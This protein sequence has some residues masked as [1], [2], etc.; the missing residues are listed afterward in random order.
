LVIP[1]TSLSW[2]PDAKGVLSAELT[3]A[4]ADQD[5]HGSWKARVAHVYT[6][7]LPSGTTPS[8]ATETSVKFEMPYRDSDHLRF[9]VRDDASGH[10]GSSEINLDP[11]KT[12]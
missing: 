9:V 2:A 4:G 5:K 3:I 12:S 1:S 11:T 6:V 8:P 7:S 10:I